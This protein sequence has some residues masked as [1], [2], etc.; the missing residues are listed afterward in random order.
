MLVKLLRLSKNNKRFPYKAP[1]K[2]DV[3]KKD[4]IISSREL[5]NGNF[6]GV[7]I[8]VGTSSSRQ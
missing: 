2:N 6:H 3:T 4:L 8:D 7:C 5:A 1:E